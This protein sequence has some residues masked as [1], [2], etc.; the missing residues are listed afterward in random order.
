VVARIERAGTGPAPTLVAYCGDECRGISQLVADDL[1]MMNVYGNSGD[2][3]TFRALNT[4]TGE[5]VDVTPADAD[6]AHMVFRSDIV[7]TLQQPVLFR[8][9][10]TTGIRTVDNVMTNATI[11]DMNGR[12]M[13]D[14]PRKHGVYIVT[15]KNGP[16]KVVK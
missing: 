4:V 10:S 9:G 1:L 2:R 14:T 16:Q 13:N 15:G 3:I 5:E 6:D 12:R 11:Y 8:L 7:G